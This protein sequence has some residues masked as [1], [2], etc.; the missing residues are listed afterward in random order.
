MLIYRRTLLKSIEAYVRTISQD[1]QELRFQNQNQIQHVRNE[2]DTRKAAELD[3]QTSK[4]RAEI[5]TWISQIDHSS[6]LSAALRHVLQEDSA[7]DWFIESD[8]YKAWLESEGHKGI[9]LTGSCK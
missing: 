4:T 7:G 6:N 5:L 9:L 2:L 8:Q 1:L 3:E